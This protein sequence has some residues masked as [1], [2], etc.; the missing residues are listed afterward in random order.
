MLQNRN[1][2]ATRKRTFSHCCLSLVGGA[3]NLRASRIARPPQRGQGR[4]FT[5]GAN[6]RRNEWRHAKQAK[7]NRYSRDIMV[8]AAGAFGLAKFPVGLVIY[9]TWNNLLSTVQQIIVMRK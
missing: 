9:W 7:G 6:G 8:S 2:W 3:L 1:P 5:P 4:S